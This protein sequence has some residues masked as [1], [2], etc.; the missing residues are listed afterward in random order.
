[1]MIHHL[2]YPEGSSVNDFIPKEI[3]SV[4][5]ATIQDAIDFI[6]HS[7]KPVYMAKVDVESAFRIIAIS[8]ADRPL[9][10]FQWKGKFF[11]DVVLPMGCSSSC[12]IFECF[13]TSL[14]WAAKVKLGVTGMVHVIYDFL[15]L[16]HSVDKCNHD[17]MAFVALCKQ[18]GVPLAPSKTVGPSS[19]ILFLGII[20]VAVHM[21]ARLP[22][23]NLEKAMSLLLAFKSKQKVTLKELQ[24]L[25]GVLNVACS[26]VVPGRAFLRRLIDLTMGL[27]K[28]H[29]HIRF[30]REAELDLG[31]W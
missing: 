16:A 4:Q 11:M 14:E 24:S 23:D 20:L 1:M 3:S 5:Y 9:L 31:V 7:P 8:P 21:E 27:R 22:G 12:A 30:T 29:H 28:P 10:G 2:S 13:S 6:Q 19:S 26:V 15:L 25:I 18:I 17:L